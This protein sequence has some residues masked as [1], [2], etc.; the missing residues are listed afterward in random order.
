MKL[1]YS[2][3]LYIFLLLAFFNLVDANK[4]Y[5]NAT[6]IKGKANY[7]ERGVLD[8]LNAK[9]K[10]AMNQLIG[11]YVM[12]DSSKSDKCKTDST[13]LKYGIRNLETW[14]LKSKRY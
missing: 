10:I 8:M 14:A 4:N 3:I 6:R 9:Q 7:T 5:N 11:F 12:E 13:R 2:S 1:L